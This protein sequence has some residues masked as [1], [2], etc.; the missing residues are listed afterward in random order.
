MRVALF[1]GTALVADASLLSVNGGDNTALCWG[2][3]GNFIASTIVLRFALHIRSLQ[4]VAMASFV[5]CIASN[6]VSLIRWI[7][8]IALE[9]GGH[10]GGDQKKLKLKK[11]LLI[12]LGKSNLLS[13]LRV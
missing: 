7:R 6:N 4:S 8:V 1:T 3:S 12:A 13:L 5:S 2:V 9:L 10:C 11:V